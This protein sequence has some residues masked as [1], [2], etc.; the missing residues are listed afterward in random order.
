MPL[1]SIQ[2]VID[3]LDKIILDCENKQSRQAIL[4]RAMTE[5]VKNG[6][7]NGKFDDAERMEK[8]D[9]VFCFEVY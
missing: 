2:Q 9:I 7:E 8:L 3:E 4:Y 1:N 5:S 6:I